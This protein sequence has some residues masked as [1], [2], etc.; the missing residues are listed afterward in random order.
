M[1]GDPYSILG[2]DP[3][4]TAA[5]IKERFRFLSH[6]YHPDKFATIA[7]RKAAEQ[8]FK[9]IN[10]AYQ[11]LSD[12]IERANY[13]RQRTRARTEPDAASTPSP[14]PAPPRSPRDSTIRSKV[15]EIGNKHLIFFWLI[16]AEMLVS[17]AVGK[18]P[19]TF[20]TLLLETCTAGI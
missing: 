4:A 3:A 6:A 17:A 10:E 18:H 5:E 13:D 8:E 16:A 9:R 14:P 19:Y 15:P 7:Q 20:Y 11:V 2:V 1:T 12:P